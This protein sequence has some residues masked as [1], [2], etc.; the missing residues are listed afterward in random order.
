[1]SRDEHSAADRVSAGRLRPPQPVRS[2]FPFAA[3]CLAAI[4]ASCLLT[5]PLSAQLPGRQSFAAPSLPGL[6]GDS[7]PSKPQPPGLP[8]ASDLP[9]NSGLPGFGGLP[10][11][12]SSI[13]AG[14]S[15]P[16][17]SSPGLAIPPRGP[18]APEA[19]P[20]RTAAVPTRM[21]TVSPAARVDLPAG[22]AAETIHVTGVKA[23][24]WMEGSREVRVFPS[25][26]ELRQGKTRVSARR[27]VLWIDVRSE[28]G[29]TQ[30]IGSFEGDV[31]VEGTAARLS[32][33]EFTAEWFTRG[34]PDFRLGQIVREDASFD[35]VFARA[36]ARRDAIDGPRM[37]LTRLTRAQLQAVE[38]LGPGLLPPPEGERIEAGTAREAG[39]LNFEMLEDVQPGRAAGELPPP[40][41]GGGSRRIRAL[42]RSSQ[43]YQLESRPSGRGDEQ[44]T[45]ITQ[46]VNILVDGVE[47]G[48]QTS[49]VD[50]AADRVIIWSQGGL[51]LTGGRPS[52][53]G[54]Q[55]EV[56]LEGN[57]VFRQGD[58]VVYADRMY[59]DVSRESGVVLNAEL[60]TQ[61][62]QFQGPLRVRADVLRQEGRD[63]FR[64]RGAWFSTSGLAQPRYRWETGDLYLQD[65]QMP[66]FDGY[67]RQPV[68]DPRNGQQVVV[69]EQNLSASDNYLYLENVPI[70]Y[71]PFLSGSPDDLSTIPQIKLKN[72]RVFGTQIL[73]TFDAYK[74][75]GLK[76][77]EGHRWEL[78]LD[79]MS[80]RGL[81]YGTAYGYAGSAAPGRPSSYS[82]QWDY[83]AIYDEGKDN[84]GAG[85][86]SIQPEFEFRLR[87]FG[88]HRQR[89]DNGLQITLESGWINERNFLEQYFE[90]E[91]DTFK[92]QTT[93]IEIKRLDENSSWTLWTDVQVNDFMT[94]TSWLPRGDHFLL[95]E[96][97]LGRLQWFEH[98]QLGYA[99]Y[100][101]ASTPTDPEDLA[102]FTRRP[103]EVD[104]RGERFATRQ[105]LDLPFA[106][107][108]VNI[109][110]Y[111][112]GEFAHWGQDLTGE[113]IQRMYGQV[114]VRASLPMSG[115][116]P[117][118]HL[119]LLNV[120]G[121]AHKIVFTMDAF[122]AEADKD[123]TQFPLYD[124][125][126][127]DSQEHFRRRFTTL[128]YG[129]AIPTRFDERNYAI[130][131]GI[132]GFVAGPSTEM[133]DD[134]DAVRVGINQRWQTKRGPRDR[135]HIIDWI[136]L[137][138]GVTYFPQ[139]D[140]DNFG[141]DFG[142]A[143]YDFLWHPGDRVSVFSSG[144]FDFFE[145]GQKIVSL[146]ATLAR[147]PR[148]NVTGALHYIDG[149]VQ[150]QILT[151]AYD[152][153]MSPKWGLGYAFSF[154]LLPNGL[155]GHNLSVSRIGESFITRLGFVYNSSK[156]NFGVVFSIE[157]RFLPTGRSSMYARP[158]T[159]V[160]G[161]NSIE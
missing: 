138:A 98:T 84:L 83:W 105:E 148:G 64:A 132:G 119:P 141:Q 131:S 25:G 101:A 126:D 62:P 113:D 106:V 140:R 91:W 85:R 41:A 142:L 10:G 20:L 68:V 159:L 129:G 110:P 40:P 36:K 80:D 124:A 121:L 55:V 115:V 116:D 58:R 7:N 2:R 76:A 19:P 27:G 29:L 17:G 54:K 5:P 9:G 39:G 24:V 102:N 61:L 59:Y 37:R 147:P 22:E 149:A 49:A 47:L 15:I 13:S 96:T 95:G 4:T 12:G 111:A 151:A 14:S 145:D 42:P 146:G 152:Y 35:A 75:L 28:V 50:L 63:S 157:P 26:I 72:D 99:K 158:P 103:Y 133:A 127:D 23:I 93:G 65:R 160:P 161:S 117:D 71:W 90:T 153:R 92:D 51:D 135:P 130:R 69:H 38:P 74:A 56:Y 114:G 78:D 31:Q 30:V 43:P 48:G 94:Q 144:S 123:F 46:G 156:N 100:G 16:A 154:D 66:L 77:P 21:P 118:V 44:V 32:D 136:T 60:F 88:R 53:A 3:V 125:I 34:D 89:F 155:T 97:I 81:G 57:I 8:G 52:E 112:L 6:G 139:P 18:V 122:H 1:M 11:S 109:V 67:T 70:F 128:T 86:T 134:L 107:G 108:D 87:L 73:T 82:G 120:H 150:S 33:A 79:Y 143:T 137:D 45:V 104:S